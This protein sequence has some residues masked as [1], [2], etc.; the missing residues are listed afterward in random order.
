[1]GVRAGP[2]ALATPHKVCTQ[3]VQGFLRIRVIYGDAARVV[4][5][6]DYG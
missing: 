1:M 5:G 3:L 2:W 4:I 6:R